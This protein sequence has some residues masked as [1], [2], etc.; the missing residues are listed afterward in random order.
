M[1]DAKAERTETIKKIMI[2]AFTM[3]MLVGCSGGTSTGGENKTP[4][5]SKEMEFLEKA[6][7]VFDES[8]TMRQ[9]EVD[10]HVS[11]PLKDENGEI[12]IDEYQNSKVSQ[13]HLVNKKDAFLYEIES[14]DGLVDH[15]S[16]QKYT[17][18]EMGIGTME[19]FEYNTDNNYYNNHVPLNYFILEGISIDD[20][21][22]NFIATNPIKTLMEKIGPFYTIKLEETDESY[23]LRFNLSDVKGYNDSFEM[24]GGYTIIHGFGDGSQIGGNLIKDNNEYIFDKDYNLIESHSIISYDFGNNLISTDKTTVKYKKLDK[25][26]YSYEEVMKLLSQAKQQAE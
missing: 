12:K 16:V 24:E 21:D 17:D 7:K 20:S 23:I 5:A 8:M 3:F 25:M 22:N 13:A 14:F 4:S 6:S 10:M 1:L 11:F 15:I 2:L 18:E 26:K 19:E 9:E